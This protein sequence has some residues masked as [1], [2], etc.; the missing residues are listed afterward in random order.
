MNISPNNSTL[1]AVAVRIGRWWGLPLAV[2]SLPPLLVVLDAVHTAR[3]ES[4]PLE[5]R[6]LASF[7]ASCYVWALLAPLMLWVAKRFGVSRPN[8]LAAIALHSVTI[9]CATAIDA[10]VAGG[11]SWLI[12][13]EPRETLLRHVYAASRIGTVPLVYGGTLL[14]GYGLS[15]HRRIRERDLEA[16]RLSA[17]LSEARLNALRMQLNPHFLFNSLN[18]IAGLVREKDNRTAVRMIGVLSGVLRH[19][20]STSDVKEV[21]LR[22]ELA[23]LREY[24][25]LEQVRFPDR[26]RV[27]WRA[28]DDVLDASI[29]SMLLQPVVENAL[30]HGI[31]RRSAP[32]LLEIAAERQ[33]ATL[34]IT[35]RDD[36][37]GFDA[38]RRESHDG[39]GLS[40]TRARLRQLYEDRARLTLMNAPTAGAIVAIELPFHR[41]ERDARSPEF[42]GAHRA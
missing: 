19:A 26:L 38:D 29:P 17:Q 33:G 6:Q 30:R 2:W 12:A 21:P 27:E 11:V 34:R 22:D 1:R 9:L 13:P 37:P 16:A 31:H 3:A 20:L 14:V 36:G 10:L 32:G 40:N 23:F 42:A 41:A 7:I 4:R 5:L 39:V 24:L 35:V 8:R 25:E 15:L 28:A 18:A